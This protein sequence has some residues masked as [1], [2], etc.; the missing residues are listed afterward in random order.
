MPDDR[1]SSLRMMGRADSLVFGQYKSTRS[2]PG[3]GEQQVMAASDE[4][5]T[6]YGVT[7]AT[8]AKGISAGVCGDGVCQVPASTLTT[9]AAFGPL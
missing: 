2:R 1:R 8:N 4:T 3:D 5:P 9:R 6:L 7:T